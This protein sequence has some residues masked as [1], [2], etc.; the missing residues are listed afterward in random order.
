MDY[1]IRTWRKTVNAPALLFFDGPAVLLVVLCVTVMKPFFWH[2]VGI[3]LFS[4]Y[5][6]VTDQTPMR[7]FRRLLFRVTNQWLGRR[8][9]L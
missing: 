8:I 3:L 5:L 6:R 4:G 9:S 2:S 1:G 7:W